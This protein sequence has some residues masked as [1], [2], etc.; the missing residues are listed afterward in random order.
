[1]QKTV[2]GEVPLPKKFVNFFYGRGKR[3]SLIGLFKDLLL[4]VLALFGGRFACRDILRLRRQVAYELC[5]KNSR[6]MRIHIKQPFGQ[7]RVPLH[8]CVRVDMSPSYPAFIDK[9]Y[10]FCP[11]MVEEKRI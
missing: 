3:Y 8:I 11:I 5:V 6:K 1:M 4:T 7:C 10:C 9:A 2:D